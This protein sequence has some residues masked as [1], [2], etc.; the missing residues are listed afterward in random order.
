[1]DVAQAGVSMTSLTGT[2]RRSPV[3]QMP[4]L[5]VVASTR[6]TARANTA[7]TGGVEIIRAGKRE[8]Q[9]D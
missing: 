8:E 4:P 7:A 5:P 9:H 1:M 3:L 2:A 6:T